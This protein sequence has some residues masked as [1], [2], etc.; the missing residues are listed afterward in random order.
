MEKDNE[1]N[2]VIFHPSMLWG[3]FQSL[4]PDKTEMVFLI[5]NGG[6]TLQ[7]FSGKLFKADANG[8]YTVEYTNGEG[9]CVKKIYDNRLRL[10]NT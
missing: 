8:C 9:E 3:I 1:V 6:G 5:H 10:C 2:V 7:Y 4:I